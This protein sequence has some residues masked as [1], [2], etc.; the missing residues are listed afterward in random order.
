MGIVERELAAFELSEIDTC[1]IE[2]NTVGVIHIHLDHC[3]IE[4]SPDEFDHFATVIREANETL[5]EIK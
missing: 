1:Y 5:Q 4:M 2:Y 3:R